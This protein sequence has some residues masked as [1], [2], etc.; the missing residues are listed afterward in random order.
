MYDFSVA[1]IS[2]L[3]LLKYRKFRNKCSGIKIDLG[4]SPTCAAIYGMCITSLHF[5]VLHMFL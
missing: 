1:L 4:N 3:T 5:V 2:A